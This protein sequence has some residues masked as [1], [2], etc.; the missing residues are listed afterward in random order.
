[1]YPHIDETPLAYALLAR[2]G[3]VVDLIYNPLETRL[4]RE[5]RDQ[6]IHAVNGLSML[7]AQAVAAE[8]IW[9]GR[10]LAGELLE[11]V[12]E[13]LTRLP[14]YTRN[15]VFI[16]MPG[17]GKST[18]GQLTAERLGWEFC[19]I[20]PFIEQRAG[21]SISEIFRLEGE[22]AF[23]RLETEAIREFSSRRRVL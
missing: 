23:R 19:D 5:A 4:M 10:K 21:H 20:D 12:C 17:S 15:L 13:F 6:E 3:V 8:E 18:L 22:E 16:G 2:F 11:P 7:A 9:Q 1:M 14:E